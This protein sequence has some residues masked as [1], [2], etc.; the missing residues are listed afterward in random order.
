MRLT[1]LV[2]NRL[3]LPLLVLALVLFINVI[4][5]PEFFHLQIKDGRLYGSLID[6]LNRSAPC[7][8][9]AI[10]MSLVIATGGIDLSVG[11]IIAISGAICANLLNSPFDALS[12]VILAGISAGLLAGAVNGGLVSF[13]GVQPIVATLVLMVAGRGIAQLI[14]GGQIITFQNG[15]FASLGVGSVL[16]LPAPVVIVL[17]VFLLTQLLVRLTA[18]GLFIEATGCNPKASHHAGLH[19]RSIK[20]AVY[21]FS[22]IC[23][24][25]AGMIVTADIQGADANNAGLWLELDAIL[26]VVLGGASL[27][28]GRFSLPLTLIGVLIIQTMTTTIIMSGVEPKFNLLIK[29]LIIVAILLAQSQILRAQLKHFFSG[30]KKIA[31]DRA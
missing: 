29:S 30:N 14:N 26:A 8:L 13:F 5:S 11:A 16:G 28:G 17:G 15:P 6:I 7:A 10:G 20:F 12:L 24:A 2:N 21:C 4:L 3:F 31:G 9:L 23:A 25:L 18:L 19:V 22:G 1:R 27:A